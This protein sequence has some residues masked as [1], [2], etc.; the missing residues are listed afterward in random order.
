MMTI[1]SGL[2]THVEIEEDDVEF[3]MA[4]QLQR[5]GTAT[6][7]GDLITVELQQIR[8]A[9]AQRAIVVDDQ[10]ADPRF[11]LRIERGQ[12][13]H[14]RC[15]RGVRVKMRSAMWRCRRR[16]RVIPRLVILSDGMSRE[17]A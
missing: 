17:R 12:S 4:E 8:A 1:V 11:H 15:G 3:A 10:E 14:S 5:F 7:G 6:G 13:N 2:V 9:L 16:H